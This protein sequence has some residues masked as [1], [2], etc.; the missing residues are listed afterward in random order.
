MPT[1]PRPFDP[2]AAEANRILAEDIYK[3]DLDSFAPIDVIVEKVDETVAPP[4]I[5][6]RVQLI[7]DNPPTTP[8]KTTTL[9][10]PWTQ[11][12]VWAPQPSTLVSS[13][14]AEKMGPPPLVDSFGVLYI[15]KKHNDGKILFPTPKFPRNLPAPKDYKPLEIYPTSLVLGGVQLLDGLHYADGSVDMFDFRLAEPHQTFQVDRCGVA[16]V[17]LTKEGFARFN[18]KWNVQELLPEALDVLTNTKQYST[19]EIA[20]ALRTVARVLENVDA[21]EL[22]TLEPQLGRLLGRFG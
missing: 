2:K 14:T 18:A 4:T 10:I 13:A 22:D 8:P 7:P 5:T 9:T 12:S 15:H 1:P 16:T 11:K 6:V 20:R 19:G 17:S 3:N 21:D